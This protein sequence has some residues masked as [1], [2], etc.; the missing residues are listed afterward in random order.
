MQR[1][2]ITNSGKNL[3][4]RLAAGTT[5]A[6]FTKVTT[7]DHDY[8]DTDLETIT[9]LEE[10][11][12]TAV[13]S[14][15]N[16]TSPMLVDVLAALDN[17]LLTE[18]YYVRAL[19][20]YA[21][22]SDG[23]EILYAISIDPDTP[24]YI[25]AFAGKTVSSVTYRLITRVDNSDQITLEVSTGAVPTIE[26]VDA[27]QKMAELHDNADVCSENGVHGIRYCNDRMQVRKDDGW[28]DARTQI[29]SGD[30][31]LS[32]SVSDSGILTV[33]YDDGKGDA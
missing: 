27:I 21:K 3:M 16:K 30:T 32:F 25:P 5:A 11:R 22:D 29:K 13:I 10:T 26:Q 15:V 24:D 23:T 17:S 7:S 8:S 12:Q 6:T 19:G 33:T 18:G 2:I 20:L 9:E 31:E 28:V 14:K 1:L 4:S